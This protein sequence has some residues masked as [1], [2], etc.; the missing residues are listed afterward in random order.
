M[1]DKQKEVRHVVGHFLVDFGCT[2]FTS[3]LY[4]Q[5]VF[6]IIAQITTTTTNHLLISFTLV[7]NIYFISICKH[8][9]QTNEILTNFS[10]GYLII[11]CNDSRHS[12]HSYKIS[13]QIDYNLLHF[14][15]RHFLRL[16]K[17]YKK[18]YV[19]FLFG[20]FIYTHT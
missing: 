9:I 11:C 8:R 10:I 4:L 2:D 15:S 1:T 19:K 6:S 18:T 13:V 17:N 3:T 7:H 14:R 16:Q 5:S 20:Y 12:R